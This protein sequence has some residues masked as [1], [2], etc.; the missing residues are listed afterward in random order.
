MSKKNKIIIALTGVIIV[1]IAIATISAYKKKKALE[2][3]TDK[4]FQDLIKKIDEA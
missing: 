3:T 2:I 4:E 1:G